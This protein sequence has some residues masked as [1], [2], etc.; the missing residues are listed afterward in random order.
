MTRRRKKKNP[1]H[2]QGGETQ[3]P[4]HAGAMKSAPAEARKV[5]AERR[6]ERT[7][8]ARMPR[9]INWKAAEFHYLEKDYLWYVGVVFV[10][11][12]LLAFAV[13]Q[14]SYFFG[15]FVL[16]ATT[17]VVEFGKR[18]PRVLEYDLGEKGISIDGT[19]YAHYEDLKSFYIRKRLG[20]L[21]EI[22]FQKSSRINPFIHLPIDE[23]LAK[24]AR[25]HLLRY[26]PEAPHEETLVEI[27]A[28]RIGF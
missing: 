1:L 20:F 17:L 3:I 26:L 2:A 9:S 25:A 16:I 7:P 14:K 27:I 11:L 19:L 21:D 13:W 4:V 6:A 28:E 24:E 8:E 15:I 18:R 23:E 22:V 10:G 5:I 12:L